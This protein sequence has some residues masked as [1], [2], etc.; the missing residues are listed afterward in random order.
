MKLKTIIGTILIILGSFLEI[1]AIYIPNGEAG[2]FLAIWAFP[3]IIAGILFLFSMVG[4]SLVFIGEII[5]IL[6]VIIQPVTTKSTAY[7]ITALMW[8]VYG[9]FILGVLYGLGEGIKKLIK[10]TKN[11]K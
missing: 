4:A 8:I 7:L 10:L 5:L 6:T 11:K 2:G 1:L 9:L 3:L